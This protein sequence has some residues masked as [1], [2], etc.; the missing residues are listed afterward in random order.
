MGDGFAAVLQKPQRLLVLPVHQDEL[1]HIEVGACRHRLKEIPA[2]D[3]A[4]RL[5]SPVVNRLTCSF[6]HMR[7][8]EHGA[9]HIRID[10][11]NGQQETAIC[12]TYIDDMSSARKIVMLYSALGNQR[13]N[14]AHRATET[15]AILGMRGVV[16]INVHSE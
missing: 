2:N 13:R 16:F 12:P 8:I 4:T 5:I 11:Q 9:E 10:I 1:E 3:L 14:V 15:G 6:Q 7:L